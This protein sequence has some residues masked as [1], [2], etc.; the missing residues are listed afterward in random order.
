[1]SESR[2]EDIL[3]DD[4]IKAMNLDPVESIPA[5]ARLR[6]VIAAMQK[7]RSSA[8]VIVE[9]ERVVGIFT[10]RDLLN[11]IVGLALNEDLLI[12]DVMTSSPRTMS[13][14]DRIADAIHLMTDRGYRHI[15]LVDDKGRNVGLLSARHIVEFIAEHYPQEVFN[16]PSDLDQVH[17]RP[18]GG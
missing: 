6:D 13:P 5:S 9:A 8:V 12:S 4:S 18:E 7:K 14:E 11:R 2:I 10:E 3:R 15:P 17:R 1:M 16:L